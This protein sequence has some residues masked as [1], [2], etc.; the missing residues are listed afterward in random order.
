MKKIISIVILFVCILVV[1]RFSAA[2]QTADL[3]G[4]WVNIDSRTRGLTKVVISKTEKGWSIS[5]WGKCHP[6]DCAWDSVLLAPL[7]SSVE[8]FSFTQGFA[9]WNAG[10][11][12]KYVTLTLGEGQLTVETV[13]IFRDRSGRANYRTMDVFQ[14]SGQRAE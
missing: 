5:A 4:E 2:G 7:G 13:N 14:R 1:S 10:F 12:T 11:A 6:K 9:V 3:E 8:D